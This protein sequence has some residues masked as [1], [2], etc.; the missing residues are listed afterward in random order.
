[1]YKIKIENG[2]IYLD[3]KGLCELWDVKPPTIT[4]YKQKGLEV[5]L[6]DGDKTQYFEVKQAESIK[7]LKV[8]DKHSKKDNTIGSENTEDG[9]VFPDGRRFYEMDIHNPIDM[10]M[11]ALHPLGEMYLDRVETAEGIKK[12]QH[13]LKVKKG[14]YILMGELNQTLAET[15]ALVLSYL[16]MLREQLPI[17]QTEKLIQNKLIKIKDKQLSV[18]LISKDADK[19]AEEIT[20]DIDDAMLKRTSKTTNVAILFLEKLIEK[21][22]IA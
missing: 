20:K 14:E 2:N 5:K 16:V 19:Y 12:K 3:A 15:F 7:I 6:F 13:D 10:E 1:M 22:K 4:A 18:E 8:K 11:I 17:S 9:T 21:V